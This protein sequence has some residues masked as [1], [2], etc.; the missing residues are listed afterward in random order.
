[1]W[2]QRGVRQAVHLEGIEVLVEGL[3]IP[4]GLIS[5]KEVV[6]EKPW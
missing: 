5:V 3:M 1:M 6:G 4:F 2:M